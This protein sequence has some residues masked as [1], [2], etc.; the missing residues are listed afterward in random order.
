M[1]NASGAP[2]DGDT[3]G[4]MHRPSLPPGV[5]EGVAFAVSDAEALGLSAGQLR[6]SDLD[7][8]FRGVRG[9]D[10]CLDT[11][12]D[13][14]RAYRPVLH[15]NAVFSHATAARVYG[16]PLPRRLEEEGA[17]LH[18]TCAEPTRPRVPGVV[19]HRERNLRR[20]EWGDLP[21]AAPADVWCQLALAL[22]D[23]EL[24]ALGDALVS[25]RRRGGRR[26]PALCT[27][28]DLRAA[29]ARRSPAKGTAKLR[30][31]V[32]RVRAG[33]DSP[34][35]TELRLLLIAAGLP[36]PVV[37]VAAR[38]R[39]GTA[40]RVAGHLVHP[41]LAYPERRIAIEYEGD[42]HRTDQRQWRT[43]VARVR[44]LEAAGWIVV[45]VTVEDLR[46]P[47]DVLRDVRAALASR[48]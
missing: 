29:V 20:V 28:G 17:P 18:V 37:G 1:E 48:P 38:A 30:D 43:D 24:V 7:R 44:A 47:D 4:R 15:P 8:P 23:G 46:R 19:G 2:R 40:V 45:R 42:Y 6:R 13:R 39:D 12:A 31:A 14:C 33:T 26:H 22:D 21:L 10:L 32:G 34:R 5:A 11:V 36:E 41:D 35:E 16:L 9:R 3:M 25:P 27:I